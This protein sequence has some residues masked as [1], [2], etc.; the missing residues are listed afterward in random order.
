VGC[1]Q[2]KYY[3]V[4][5]RLDEEW[6]ENKLRFRLICELIETSIEF[7]RIANVK[8]IVALRND[9]L[10]QVYRFTR[11]PGFQEEKYRSSSLDLI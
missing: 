11:D 4:I 3:I 10:D 1:S 5:D 6:V 9:L 8:V 2:K 7:T